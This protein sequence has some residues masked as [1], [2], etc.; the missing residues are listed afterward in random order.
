ME[1]HRPSSPV[2]STRGLERLIAEHHPLPDALE[3]AVAFAQY[4]V[5]S[6]P[7]LSGSLSYLHILLPLAPIF[8]SLFGQEWQKRGTKAEGVRRRQST[9]D[10]RCRSRRRRRKKVQH[11]LSLC[12][13]EWY[14]ETVTAICSK[15]RC[16]RRVI[17]YY[18]V[19]DSRQGTRTKMGQ[20]RDEI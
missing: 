4:D 14:S 6:S 19:L 5:L 2:P 1:D 10:V 3:N 7:F 15:N 8:R 12:L 9:R 20:I 13:P 16:G 11:S 17:V 18:E